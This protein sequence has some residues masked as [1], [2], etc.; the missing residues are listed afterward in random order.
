MNA[1]LPWAILGLLPSAATEESVGGRP[2]V[3]DGVRTADGW[4]LAAQ[5]VCQIAAFGLLGGVVFW[6]VAIL[7]GR[8]SGV[9]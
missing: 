8:K 2:T 9:R 1:A 6:A 3:I 7:I 4:F 5:S